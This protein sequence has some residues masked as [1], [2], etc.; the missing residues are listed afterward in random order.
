MKYQGRKRGKT[1]T[2]LV[3]TDDKGLPIG[4]GSVLS[5]N[6]SD[7]FDLIPQCK[8]LLKELKTNEIKTAG[9]VLNMDSGFDNKAIRKLCYAN[10]IKPNVKE[11]TRNRKKTKVGRKRFFDEQM[12]KLRYVNE[13]TFAWL[14]SFKTLLIRFDTLTRNWKNWHFI[15]ATILFLKV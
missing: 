15:A 11:N 14:D 10:R 12:Y 1:S 4:Y 13:R 7:Q 9:S 2:I 3:M 5:G 6:H 8:Q